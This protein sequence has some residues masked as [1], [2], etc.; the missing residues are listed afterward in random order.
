MFPQPPNG[1]RV[2]LPGDPSRTHSLS[3]KVF[4]FSASPGLCPGL[5]WGPSL[6][7]RGSEGQPVLGVH[8]VPAGHRPQ[9]AVPPGP[10]Q[11]PTGRAPGAEW[12]LSR[13]AAGT[14]QGSPAP[15]S[16]AVLGFRKHRARSG[17]TAP[18]FL[19]LT[20]QPWPGVAWSRLSLGITGLPIISRG[21]CSPTGSAV[22][23]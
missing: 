22:V 19:Q 2:L 16:C 17:H 18:F 21:R 11:S 1:P 10:A 12:S 4:F 13:R 6:R 8:Q 7:R 5:F 14:G 20:L 3:R 9:K 15:A 23:P